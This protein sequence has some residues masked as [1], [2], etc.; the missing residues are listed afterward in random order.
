MLTLV[1][2]SSKETLIYLSYG[3]ENRDWRKYFI[4][5]KNS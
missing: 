3:G 5:K 2:G 4:P 1:G